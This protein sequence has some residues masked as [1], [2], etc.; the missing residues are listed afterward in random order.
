MWHVH[1]VCSEVVL[2]LNVQIGSSF[3]FFITALWCLRTQSQIRNHL[4]GFCR[5]HSLTDTPWQT[6][7]EERQNIAIKWTST[8]RLTDQRLNQS[9][10]VEMYQWCVSDS[11]LFIWII[12]SWM[13]R[14]TSY[15]MRTFW[16][17]VVKVLT[18]MLE[19]FV[20]LHVFLDKNTWTYKIQF[21]TSS[22][23]FTFNL[24]IWTGGCMSP[25]KY[26]ASH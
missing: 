4:P 20:L 14:Y 23:R 17:G 26:G 8:L 9:A 16:S 2:R 12:C 21:H 5:S 25:V 19:V 18:D 13:K 1:I 11:S 7:K 22:P 15:G 3:F 24:F 10:A 6:H